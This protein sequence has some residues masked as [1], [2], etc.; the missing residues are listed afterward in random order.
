MLQ[1]FLK[2]PSSF[3]TVSE[4]L[5]NLS[6]ETTNKNSR[7]PSTSHLCLQAKK[8]ISIKVELMK[9]PL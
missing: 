2:R 3:N 8:Q 4:S 1:L 5:I 7:N 9:T 6:A